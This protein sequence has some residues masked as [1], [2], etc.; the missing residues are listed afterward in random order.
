MAKQTHDGFTA[1]GTFS[2]NP[3]TLAAGGAMIKHLQENPDIYSNM[4]T[5]GE[6]LRNGFNEYVK[7]KDYPFC[8]TGL[9]S[10]FQ[11]HAKALLPKVPRDLLGQ[12]KEDLEDLQLHFRK[13]QHSAA[14]GTPG[15]FYCSP[16][17]DRPRRY[18]QR[19]QGFR[20]RGHGRQ[21]KNPVSRYFVWVPRD[22]TGQIYPY[23]N[24]A[25]PKIRSFSKERVFFSIH[26][27]IWRQE[28]V[29]RNFYAGRKL[30]GGLSLNIF[31]DDE[32]NEIHLAT[33]E[34][35]EKTGLFVADEEG[36][37]KFFMGGGA[38]I[39]RTNKIVKISPYIVE[40]A[41]Q[42]APSKLV[43]AG[44]R[45]ENDFVMESR[46]VGFTNFGEGVYIIDPYT[47]EYRETT[48]AD[49]ADSARIVDYLSDVDVY[50]RAVGAGDT[51]PETVQLHNAEA[52][53]PNTTKH[54]FMGSGNGYITRK[55][56][57]M[58]Q[59][60]A[61]G[62]EALAERPII[63]FIT[64]PVS[65]LQLIQES[66]EIIIESARSGVAVNILSMAMAGGSSPVTM[67]GTL[68]T[69]Q[70]RSSGG[71][72]TESTHPERRKSYL[73]QLHYSHGP[74]GWLP[75]RWDARNAVSSMLPW[76]VWAITTGCPPGLQV[77]RATLKYV[78]PRSVMKKP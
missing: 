26:Q 47:G 64:C 15:L 32:L 33:L 11:I 38:K 75:P 72:C 18:A 24:S 51:P 62:K 54:G 49:V 53:L 78:M 52:W 34:V 50:E 30:S 61:G 6:F 46:R 28:I 16:Y 7:S 45:P 67:A 65:P 20:G 44:R 29:K 40:E 2:G 48:K 58:A 8:M 73:R 55:L 56:V 59:A 19:L 1:A 5:K 63:S 77:D 76:P 35:L 43:L 22:S 14:L 41:I 37:W 21:I 68:V 39:D 70:R 4:M 17:T 69:P 25:E 71:H 74:C 12:D 31:T 9:G 13:K 23:E 60:V 42:S 10:M 27:L 3:L 66:C 36:P 57:E